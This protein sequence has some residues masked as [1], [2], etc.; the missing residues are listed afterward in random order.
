MAV[1]LQQNN[2]P[3]SNNGATLCG[4]PIHHGSSSEPR[5]TAGT[6]WESGD[7]WTTYRDGADRREDVCVVC[8]REY[9][10]VDK[11]LYC[12]KCGEPHDLDKGPDEG[13]C[14]ACG[15]PLTQ[16]GD[17]A[18]E[19]AYERY[20]NELTKSVVQGVGTINSIEKVRS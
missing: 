2:P 18:P 8:Q 4:I 11:M 6:K 5:T 3:L 10:R 19:V 20:F 12:L 15:G 1:H 7:R 13:Q 17:P 16:P 9:D 14:L